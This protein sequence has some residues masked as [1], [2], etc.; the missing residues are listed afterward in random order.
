MAYI[1]LS[2]MTS[3]RVRAFD[4]INICLQTGFAPA[5]ALK[6]VRLLRDYFLLLQPLLLL[7]IQY[8]LKIISR[9]VLTRGQRLAI[10]AERYRGVEQLGSSLGS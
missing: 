9:L 4:T 5:I 10:L 1:F 6:V 7:S 2:A 3:P 8:N